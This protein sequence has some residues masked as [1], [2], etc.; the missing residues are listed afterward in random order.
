MNYDIMD[1][2]VRTA[3]EAMRN[4]YVS[5]GSIVSGAC[6]LAS[7]GTLYSGCS[8]DSEV[9]EFCLPAEVVVIT[10]AISEGKHEFDAI[11]IVA[12]IE[13]VYAPDERAYK[14]LSEF[15]IPEIIL[16]D[17]D[18]NM[19]IMPFKDLLPYQNRLK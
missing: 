19:K 8:I 13:G 6:L 1:T 14:Y 15:N 4:S 3:T 2:I 10:K 5:K 18:G 16:A 17:L 7:D 12:E 9:P 11:S